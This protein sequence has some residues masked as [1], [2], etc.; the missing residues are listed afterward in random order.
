MEVAVTYEQRAL[1]SPKL[2]HRTSDSEEYVEV[3]EDAN[4][5]EQTVAMA[6]V[7]EGGAYVVEDEINVGAVVAIV[8]A[9]LVFVGA[10]MF[11]VW[12]QFFKS[13]SASDDYSVNQGSTYA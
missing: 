12:W 3:T 8:V 4:G 5:N 11:I 13:P 2:V 6:Y 10:V 9:G 1:Y 7:N